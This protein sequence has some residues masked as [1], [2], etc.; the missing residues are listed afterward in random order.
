MVL[1]DGR[2][3]NACSFLA[4]QAAGRAVTTVEG[5]ARDGRLSHLQQALVDGGG[6]QCGYCTPGVVISATALL[7]RNPSPSDDEVREALAGNL[8]RC[9]GYAKIF[10]AVHE[11]ARRERDERAGREDAAAEG[12]P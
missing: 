1:L 5:I 2:P 7:A 8:C 4:L 6:V 12:R 10:A 3:V 9:T 11:A